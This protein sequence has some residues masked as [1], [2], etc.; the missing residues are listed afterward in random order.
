MTIARF[1]RMSVHLQLMPVLESGEE[2]LVG[3]QAVMEGV[4]MRAPH[5]YCVA[6]RKPSGEIVTEDH[7][8]AADVGKISLA[9]YPMLRGWACW[10]RR[11][12]WASGLKFSANAALDDGNIEE[13]DEVSSWMMT[14]RCFLSWF[15]SSLCIN[16]SVDSGRLFEELDS[17]ALRTLCYQWVD[18]VIRLVIF[19][20][21]LLLF[22]ARKISVAFSNSTA[23]SIRW[24][25]ISNRA[26]RS[27]WRMPS[28]L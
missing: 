20:G 15:S 1:L 3:G 18:G 7:A 6:V 9:K 5:S 12:L 24:S 11:C 13:A 22:R 23:R 28:S 8:V 14:V 25:S 17:G 4:M 21:F 10:D 2:T 16:S 26:N 27:M 19:V